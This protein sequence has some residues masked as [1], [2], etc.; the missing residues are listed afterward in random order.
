MFSWDHIFNDFA[1]ILWGEG[2]LLNKN[3]ILESA[4]DWPHFI[5]L[6]ANPPVAHISKMSS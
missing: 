2:N 1:Y 3:D 5:Q 4:G 6:L